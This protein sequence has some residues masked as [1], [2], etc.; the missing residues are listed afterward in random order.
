MNQAAAEAVTLGAHALDGAYPKWREHVDLGRL[1]VS[2]VEHCVLAQAEVGEYGRRHFGTPW[3]DGMRRLFGA[4][5]SAYGVTHG[6]D[7]TGG[8]GFDTDDL[9]EAWCALLSPAAVLA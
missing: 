4:T 9:Y 3:G 7:A 8:C 1:D 2:S 6:F 5:D